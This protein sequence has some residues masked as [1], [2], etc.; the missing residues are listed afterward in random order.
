LVCK[1]LFCTKLTFKGEY[2]GVNKSIEASTTFTVMDA[3]D[4][5]KLF[6]GEIPIGVRGG[7][8]FLYGRHF[9]PTVRQSLKYK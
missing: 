2:G 6:K 1:P 7:T 5:A 9:N 8:H 4:M 3:E